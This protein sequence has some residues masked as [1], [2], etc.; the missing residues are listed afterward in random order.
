MQYTTTDPS[1]VVGQ[2]VKLCAAHVL[3]IAT[4]SLRPLYCACTSA[5]STSEALYFSA[6]PGACC[7]SQLVFSHIGGPV[8]VVPGVIVP[9]AVVSGAECH[10]A[11][12]VRQGVVPPFK[13]TG[14]LDLDK[15]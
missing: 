14:A 8:A 10:T 15:R 6:I 9:G 5:C 2:S 1:A 12:V 11:K 4:R 13:N 7:D 3:G